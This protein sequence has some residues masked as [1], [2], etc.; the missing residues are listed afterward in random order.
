MHELSAV[1]IRILPYKSE[2]SVPFCLLFVAEQTVQEY[3]PQGLASHAEEPASFDFGQGKV[4]EFVQMRTIS[5]NGSTQTVIL[6]EM[7][8]IQP[9]GDASVNLSVLTHQVCCLPANDGESPAATECTSRL[10]ARPAWKLSCMVRA[11][12]ECGQSRSL[13]HKSK[14]VHSDIM[15]VTSPVIDVP[16]N[17]WAWANEKY[18]SRTALGF[19]GVDPTRRESRQLYGGGN[20]GYESSTSAANQH[21]IRILH[22]LQDF[23]TATERAIPAK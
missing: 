15:A 2:T 11:E 7:N 6:F 14:G 4:P 19:H 8:F 23:K 9:V 13:F 10:T 18:Q 3:K 1:S 21:H 16:P 20:A 17:T 12:T 5:R 22:L